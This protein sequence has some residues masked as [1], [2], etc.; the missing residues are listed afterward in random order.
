[1]TVTHAE[2][3][4]YVIGDPITIDQMLNNHE[5]LSE[6]TQAWLDSLKFTVT[7]TELPYRDTDLLKRLRERI[8]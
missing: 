3:G 4:L 5:P 2:D 1:M 8:E 7:V 6:E